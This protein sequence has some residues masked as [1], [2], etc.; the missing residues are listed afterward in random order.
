[1]EREACRALQ[2]RQVF[3]AGLQDEIGFVGMEGDLPRSHRQRP[4]L[5][6]GQMQVDQLTDALHR[7]N[8]EVQRQSMAQLFAVTVGTS[9]QHE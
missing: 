3:G 7:A 2:L 1:M 8:L 5:D 4:D 6:T 9:R